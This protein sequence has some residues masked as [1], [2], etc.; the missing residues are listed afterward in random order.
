M[1]FRKY[2]SGPAEQAIRALNYRHVEN[3]KTSLILAPTQ[4]NNIPKNRLYQSNQQTGPASYDYAQK[5]SHHR[6][7]KNNNYSHR[8]DLDNNV[9]PDYK[10]SYAKGNSYEDDFFP[11]LSNDV[12]SNYNSD[13]NAKF[14]QPVEPITYE[15]QSLK[16]RDN[17]FT[18][19]S[20]ANNYPKSTGKINLLYRNDSA[21]FPQ[22]MITFVHILFARLNVI[23]NITPDISELINEE[24]TFIQGSECIP[25]ATADFP[26]NNILFKEQQRV[27]KRNVKEADPILD[28]HETETNEDSW[29]CDFCTFLNTKNVKICQMCGK[30][31]KLKVDESFISDGKP[32]PKCT[33]LNNKVSSVCDA[34]GYNI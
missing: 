17:G 14:V 7:N 22:G 28:R 33:L 34:C 1:E 15:I 5:V 25:A 2:Y 9:K 20:E 11:V 12:P 27:N 3:F 26:Q 10:Y 19:K 16:I 18:P 6:E 24:P 31:Q 8:N 30:T 21:E 13:V 29:N 32:C 23:L 4:P